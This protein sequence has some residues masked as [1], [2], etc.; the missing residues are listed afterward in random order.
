MTNLTYE[1]ANILDIISDEDVKIMQKLKKIKKSAEEDYKVICQSFTFK[2]N[3]EKV[4]YEVIGDE[5]YCGI[6]IY[7]YLSR[8]VLKKHNEHFD[9]FHI[10]SEDD[11][12]KYYKAQYLLSKK[13]LPD[14]ENEKKE[15]ETN[16]YIGL[17]I[18]KLVHLISDGKLKLVE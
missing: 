16:A 4:E 2:F 5:K 13:L 8:F 6:Q 3:Q 12:Y 18:R 7:H 9:I 14:D 10:N 17:V 11:M 15:F 1:R